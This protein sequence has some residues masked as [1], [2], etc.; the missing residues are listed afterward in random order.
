M[1]GAHEASAGKNHPRREPQ[2]KIP[3]ESD[4]APMPAVGCEE[5]SEPIAS[6]PGGQVERTLSSSA[7]TKGRVASPSPCLPSK[8]GDRDHPNVAPQPEGARTHLP[9]LTGHSLRKR[10]AKGGRNPPTSERSEK[11]R[12]CNLHHPTQTNV[13]RW[14]NEKFGRRTYPSGNYMMR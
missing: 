11:L 12:W 9:L 10:R 6:S 7:E 1:S 8:E 4:S 14:G 2:Q 3:E 5:R 13:V